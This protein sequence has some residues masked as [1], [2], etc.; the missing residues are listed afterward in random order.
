MGPIRTVRVGG[1]FLTPAAHS[2]LKD[3]QDYAVEDGVAPSSPGAPWG[4][5]HVVL[6]VLRNRKKWAGVQLGLPAPC[7]LFKSGAL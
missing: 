2:P 1:A 7:P 6:I 3:A 4:P 5:D